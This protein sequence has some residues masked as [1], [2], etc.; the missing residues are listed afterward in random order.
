MRQKDPKKLAQMY[1]AALHI[2]STE[3]L[4]GLKMQKL[5]EQAGVAAGTLYLYFNDKESLLMAM[6]LHYREWLAIESARLVAADDAFEERF[7]KTWYNYL[8]LLQ[9]KPKVMVFLEQFQFEGM[10]HEPAQAYSFESLSPFY[11]LIA[12][13][14]A[15][16][17]IS[18]GPPR[19]HLAM[20]TAAA[21]RWVLW[22]NQ[23][24][25]PPITDFIHLAWELSWKAVKR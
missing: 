8:Q 20:L 12:E 17:I 10:L 4:S 11:Q 6:N 15:K 7:R 1:E 13:G 16:G 14:Q 25:L 24:W 21:H 19:V 18:Q 3:G 9:R 22:A 5:A 23:A 2:V